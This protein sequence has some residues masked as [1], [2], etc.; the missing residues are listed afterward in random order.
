M[1]AQ[2]QV[3]IDGSALRANLARTRELASGARVMAV[4]KANAYGHGI[5]NVARALADADALAVARMSEAIAVRDAGCDQRVLLLEG[6]MSPNELNLAARYRLDL[7]VH[8]PDQIDMLAAYRGAGEFRIWLKIDTGMN[9]LG[10][11]SSQAGFARQSLEQIGCVQSPVTLMTHLASADDPDDPTAEQQIALFNETTSGWP[12]E[13]SIANSAAVV[14]LPASH[15]DW[16]RPGLMLY[17]ASPLADRTVDDLGLTPVM[18]LWSKVIA[19][20]TLREGD[21]VGYGGT[22][23]APADTRMAIVAAGYGDGYP[24]RLASGTPVLIR[25]HRYPL[26]GRVS[27]DMIAVELGGTS[28]VTIGDEAV[29]WGPGLPVEELAGSIGTIAYE[30][31]CGIS[32]RVRIAMR[33]QTVRAPLSEHG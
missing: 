28:D 5:R 27:M 11:S 7:V 2:A 16:V 1:T 29:L 22:W 20:K 30:L 3:T 19:V 10:F 23:C 6:I 17:G 24:W 13:R 31:L 25:G 15:G 21:R 14:R 32:Q 8:R 9:R 18:T 12:G 33:S 26:I 4:I